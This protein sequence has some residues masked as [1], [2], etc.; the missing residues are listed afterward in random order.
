[1]MIDSGSSLQLLTTTHINLD[2]SSSPETSTLGTLVP[3]LGETLALAAIN[4]TIT[5]PVSMVYLA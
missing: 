2:K 1:M 5:S 3:L 4:L